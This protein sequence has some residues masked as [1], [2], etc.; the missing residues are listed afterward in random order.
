[1]RRTGVLQDVIPVA[2]VAVESYGE[3]AETP[4]F[5]EEE[6]VMQGSSLHRYRQFVAGRYCARQALVEL[7]VTPVP[8]L[9]GRLG[10]PEWPQDVV[11]SISH[12][13]GY[14]VAVVG[15]AS[16]LVAVG[17]DAEPAFP[18]PKGVF[19]LVASPDEALAHAGLSREY[20]DFCWDRLL[21]SAKEATY[22]AWSSRTG[23]WSA[24]RDISVVLDARGNFSAMLPGT[25]R[26][27]RGRWFVG[28][29]VLRAVAVE[30]ATA[31]SGE[32]VLTG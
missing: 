32:S 25:T 5:P 27:Y 11:G 15:R 26:E 2:A 21:F 12:C 3:E 14:Q 8:I 6:E 13:D 31:G 19:S 17:V 7:G 29:G 23:R 22:K 1:M 28:G 18:L 9:P 24:L 16:E 10:A 4:L 30:T 20:P